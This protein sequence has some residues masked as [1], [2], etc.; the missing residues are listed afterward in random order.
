[1]AEDGVLF[2]RKAITITENSDNPR[3]SVREYMYHHH[4]PPTK[5]KGWSSLPLQSRAANKA[6]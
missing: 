2:V 4:W 6:R 3:K 5:A 1:M